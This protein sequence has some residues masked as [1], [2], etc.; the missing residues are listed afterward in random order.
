MLD[1][2]DPL[3]LEVRTLEH[4]DRLLLA[5]FLIEWLEDEPDPE[6]VARRGARS[7]STSTRPT[8]T[9]SSSTCTTATCSGRPSTSRAR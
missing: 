1:G 5:A 8:A 3:A 2:D 6:R 4:V 7:G 9:R